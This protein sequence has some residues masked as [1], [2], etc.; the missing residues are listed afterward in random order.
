MS[1][2]CSSSIAA[3]KRLRSRADASG[4]S[5]AS[6]Q[7]C[8]SSSRAVGPSAVLSTRSMRSA[9]T[10]RPPRLRIWRVLRVICSMSALRETKMCA[11]ANAGSSASFGAW[12]PLRTSSCQIARGMSTSHAA[13]VALAVD[14]AGAVQHLLQRVEGVR[15]DVVRG[16]AVTANRRVERAGV[17]VLDRLGRAQGPVGLERRE[18]PRSGQP[19]GG[20]RRAALRRVGA[21]FVLPGSAPSPSG[22][23]TGT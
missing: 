11:T 10:R 8:G 14:V 6:C 17:L 4:T 15:D 5:T 22:R 21:Q 20:Q 1:S 13:A 18:W 2:C 16:A 23:A 3:S 7:K 19:T 12:P 9:S